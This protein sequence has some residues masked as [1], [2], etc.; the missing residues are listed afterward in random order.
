MTPKTTSVHPLAF[1]FL[2]FVVG[3]FFELGVLAAQYVA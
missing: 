2:I 1:F 3:F